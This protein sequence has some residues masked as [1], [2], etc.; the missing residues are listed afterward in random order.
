MFNR[1]SEGPLRNLVPEPSQKPTTIL[2]NLLMEHSPIS[3]RLGPTLSPSALFSVLIPLLCSFFRSGLSSG[4]RPP[5]VKGPLQTI[6]SPCSRFLPAIVSP[7]S[8]LLPAVICPCSR[9]LPA[10]V[11]SSS[12]CCDP[13][14]ES[15][16][17]EDS[18]SL[19]MIKLVID[20]RKK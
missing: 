3:V 11:C 8:R 9:F 5:L 13:Q 20:Q 6:V 19:P 14:T 17:I 16:G 4:D 7:C 12:A 18:A 15:G 2:F 10:I 1:I